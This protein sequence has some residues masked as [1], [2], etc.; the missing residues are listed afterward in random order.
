MSES[1]LSSPFFSICFIN[2]SP[3]TA[4][5]LGDALLESGK[6]AIQGRAYLP[7]AVRTLFESDLP[8]VALVGSRS[9][10]ERPTALPFVEQIRDLSPGTRQIILG[11]DLSVEEEVTLLRA[12]A[13]GLLREADVGLP[14]LLKCIRCVAEGQVWAS[15]LQLEILLSSLGRPSVLR[16]KNVL[17]ASIL[18]KREEEVLHLLAE[19]LSNRELAAALS[20]SEHTVK[21]HLFRI[22]D[23]L[24]VSS[25]MEA[26]L[27]AINY[28]DRQGGAALTPIN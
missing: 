3:M 18:S 17:G 26:V 12:G 27:Y 23:K 1:E 20:L 9:G 25:R 28:R 15:S 10:A 24:G 2:I 11:Q 13:R 19:G 21:N 6:V 8:Q 4:D 16:V 5:L 7:A 14:T 22:F